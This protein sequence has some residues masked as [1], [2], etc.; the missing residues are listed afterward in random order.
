[1]TEDWTKEF[2]EAQA[3]LP[4]TLAK[5]DAVIARI[6][7]ELATYETPKT[8]S[9]VVKLE[10]YRKWMTLFHFKS[11]R[12]WREARKAFGGDKAKWIAWKESAGD[13]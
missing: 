8:F 5:I 6:K 2:E 13:R 11:K 10:H 9:F 4:V 12:Q 1:M 3:N 7:E